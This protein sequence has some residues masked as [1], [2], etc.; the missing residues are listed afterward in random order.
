MSQ[1][2]TK[3]NIGLM[4]ILPYIP[5]NRGYILNGK[6][7]Y[8]KSGLLNTDANSV[9]I[10]LRRGF[11]EKELNL[12]D[13]SWDVFTNTERR[14]LI[15]SRAMLLCPAELENDGLCPDLFLQN[16]CKYYYHFAKYSNGNLIHSTIGHQIECKYSHSGK[17]NCREKNN[18]KHAKVFYHVDA[19]LVP[20]DLGSY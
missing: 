9:K 3:Q 13:T 6:K 15:R 20:N 12:R 10:W 8:G 4:E 14:S 7:Y 16:H 18:G 11:V 17:F 19:Q 2:Q 1:S 5:S